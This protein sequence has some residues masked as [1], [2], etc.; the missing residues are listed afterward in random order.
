[1]ILF[2]PG[3]IVEKKYKPFRLIRH[4]MVVE[5]EH[6]YYNCYDID[7]ENFVKNILLSNTLLWKVEK[8]A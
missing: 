2:V 5:G 1:L 4:F 7:S 6:P 8:L 3:D